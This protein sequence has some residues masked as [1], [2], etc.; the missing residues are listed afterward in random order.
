M[1]ARLRP[2]RRALHRRHGDRFSWQPDGNFLATAG[3]S[4]VVHI[5][6]RHG[7]RVDEVQ[8]MGEGAVLSL[9]WDSDGECLAVLQDGNG[10]IP[11]WDMKDRSVTK[12]ETSLKDPTFMKWSRTGPQLVIGTV[13]GNVLIYNKQSRK[14]VPVLGKHPRKITCG[15]WSKDNRLAL[16]SEDSTLTLSNA[17]GDTLEQTELKHPPKEMCFAIQKTNELMRIGPETPET[18]LSINMGGYSLLLYDLSDP[19]NPLELAFQSR[20][21]NILVHKWFGDGHMMLGFSEGYLVVIST[22]ITEIGEE[23]FSGRFHAK[24]LFDIAYSPEMKYAAVAGDGG[25]KVVDMHEF[26]D[27]KTEAIAIEPECGRVNRV[28]WSPD[29]KILTAATTSGTVLAFLA[30]MPT[31]HGSFGTQVAYLSSLREI[32]LIN[33]VA[34]SRQNA[35]V[36]PIG[37]EPSFLA[38]GA[39]H[40]AVGMNNRVH[41]YRCL[42]NDTTQVDEQEY[43][44]KVDRICL[45]ERYTAVLS[46]GRITLHQIEPNRDPANQRR[47]FPEREDGA[48][49]RATAMALTENFLL[50]GTQAGTVEFFYLD[51]QEWA[52][53][54]GAELRHSTAIKALYPNYLGTRVVVIDASNQGF[55][56]NSVSAELTPIPAFP[57]HVQHVMWDTADKNVFM[58]FDGQSKDLHTFV[59]T[60]HDQRACRVKIGPVDISPNGDFVMHRSRRRSRRAAPICSHDGRSRAGSAGQDRSSSHRRTSTR[61]RAARRRSTGS[62]RT[63]RCCGSS[64]GAACSSTR[65]PPSARVSGGRWR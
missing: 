21:G 13:K 51:Q 34:N 41:Y 9:E 28:E 58:V 48:F 31:V 54:S 20:Y 65:R 59:H 47:T 2:S 12:L 22:H 14:K 4:G 25:V 15:A 60:Q 11:I 39:M 30:R 57:T 49:A 55:I 8:L 36:I 23:L 44:G 6:D 7:E 27:L 63:S 35:T 10:Q 52:I 3:R 40:V 64:G 61:R 18:H 5:W 19:D 26:K 32:S 17:A 24:A 50:Y 29:G 53:L 33:S 43:L 38:L 56:Y 62:S 1:T 45:N 42:P 16:G 46:D 37:I